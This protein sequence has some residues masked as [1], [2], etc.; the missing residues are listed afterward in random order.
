MHFP[1]IWLMLKGDPLDQQRT[2]NNN[3]EG[4]FRQVSKVVG[5]VERNDIAH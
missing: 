4:Q 1:V 5:W 2:A 3:L